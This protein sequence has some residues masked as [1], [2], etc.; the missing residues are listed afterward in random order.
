[1]PHLF[2]HNAFD[3][4]AFDTDEEVVAQVTPF[5]SGDFFPGILP[6]HFPL[7]KDARI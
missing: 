2:D 7:H 1:M 3:P 4:A 6:G 5:G